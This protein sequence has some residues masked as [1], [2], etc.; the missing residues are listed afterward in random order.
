MR[1][2]ARYMPPSTDRAEN[3][4]KD[5][6]TNTA[7]Q[8]QRQQQQDSDQRAVQSG[9]ER[10]YVLVIRTHFFSRRACPIS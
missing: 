10:L 7:E 9:T 4:R 2:V 8:Q 1:A 3:D 6:P 5:R